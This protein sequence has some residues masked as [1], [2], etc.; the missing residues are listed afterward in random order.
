MLIQPSHVL[1]VKGH[2]SWKTN[3]ISWIVYML[4]S[5]EAMKSRRRLLPQSLKSQPS[6]RRLCTVKRTSFETHYHESFLYICNFHQFVL[7][8]VS[9]VFTSTKLIPRYH[10]SAD[11]FLFFSLVRWKYILSCLNWYLFCDLISNLKNEGYDCHFFSIK[12]TF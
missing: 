8:H 3:T 9:Y 6:R 4:R 11:Y 1:Y 12:S 5:G 10:F 7:L 2:C